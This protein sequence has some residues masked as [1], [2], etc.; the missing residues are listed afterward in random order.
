MAQPDDKSSYINEIT[1]LTARHD[2]SV[3]TR[4][5]EAD[6]SQRAT[7]GWHTGHQYVT[8]ASTPVFRA[9]IRAPHRR[10]DSPP[11]P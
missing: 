1:I 8:R 9:S 11:R 7:S 3:E 6:T 4:C 2:V 5:G 10:H